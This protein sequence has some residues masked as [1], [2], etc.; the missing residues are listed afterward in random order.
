M[1][2][3]P[4]LT[5][6]RSWY[7][8]ATLRILWNPK[9][10]YHINNSAP[11]PILNQNW[12]VHAPTPTSWK[13]ILILF[14]I[15]QMVSFSHISPPLLSFIRAAYPAYLI[16]LDLMNWIIIGEEHRSCSSS[17]SNFLHSPVNWSL[18]GSNIF[19]GSQL[20]NTLS[21]CLSLNVRP[22]RTPIKIIVTI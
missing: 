8:Q 1:E 17:L 13:F 12:P 9:V 2:Q 18:L 14:L 20:S 21:L 15:F 11:V 3:S 19:L 22:S 16:L 7:S 5:P 10:Q 6:N 4:S